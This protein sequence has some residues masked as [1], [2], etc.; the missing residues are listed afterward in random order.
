MS[1]KIRT[2]ELF[3]GT[4][5]FSKVAEELGCSTCTVDL[6]PELEPDYVQNILKVKKIK[7]YDVV[8]TSPPCEAFSVAAIGKNWHKDTKEPT[9]DRAALG[10]KVLDKTIQLIA[11]SKPKIWF[12][13]N[14]RGM[15]RIVIDKVFEKYKIKKYYRHTVAYCQYGDTRQK[16]TDIWTNLENWKSKPVCKPG[17]KCHEAAPRGSRTGTQA[18]KNAKLRGVIPPDIFYEIFKTIKK[19]KTFK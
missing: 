10:L 14:P 5:S 16:P 4:K 11:E 8:W 7:K 13:E 15:M 6:D 1:K 18:I 3:S 19:N 2:I 17:S 12:L 9:S